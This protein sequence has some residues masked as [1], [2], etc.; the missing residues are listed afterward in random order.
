MSE[1]HDTPE[2]PAPGLQSAL[3]QGRLPT[4]TSPEAVDALQVHRNVAAR[5]A[6]EKIV[7]LVNKYSHYQYGA[8]EDLDELVRLG[9]IAGREQLWLELV[10][11]GLIIADGDEL[12]L[13]YF[14]ANSYMTS[15]EG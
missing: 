5:N 13:V 9:E 12:D 10:E 1:Q 14:G 15:G 11:R 7:D 2:S 8:R 4:E 6:I 3:L